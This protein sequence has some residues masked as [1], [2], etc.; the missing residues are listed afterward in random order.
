MR[1]NRPYLD[2]VA[3]RVFRFTGEAKAVSE[4]ELR[5]VIKGINHL[6]APVVVQERGRKLV[7]TWKYVDAKWWEVL[8]YEFHPAK[9]MG[10]SIRYMVNVEEG[11]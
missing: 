11:G 4:K 8:A 10:C 1:R 6:D 3:K 9:W 2:F 7:V 5:T